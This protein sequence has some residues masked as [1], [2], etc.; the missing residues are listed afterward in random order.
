MK[1]LVIAAALIF[2][3]ACGGN[4]IDTTEAVQKGIVT[5]VAKRMDINAMDVN[6][7]SVSFRGKEAQAV[8]SFVPKGGGANSGVTFRYD[9]ERKGDAWEVKGRSQADMSRHQQG[10]RE[11][12][13]E[14][15]QMQAAPGG[16]LPAGH[17]PITG[18][19]AGGGTPGTPQ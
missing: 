15:G 7:T 3:I 16:Q 9:L 18:A 4:K 6:V 19:P 10:A 8:V 5:Y 17:P 2:S 13:G 12:P 14:G 11:M 1:T